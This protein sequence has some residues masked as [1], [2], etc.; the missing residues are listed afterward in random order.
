MFDLPVAKRKY[1][2]NNNLESVFIKDFIVEINNLLKG[3]DKK[4]I[5]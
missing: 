4:I 3:E 5:S 2:K 1:Y